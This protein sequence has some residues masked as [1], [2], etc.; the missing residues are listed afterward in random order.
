MKKKKYVIPD[1]LMRT[2]EIDT[3]KK[4]PLVD[5]LKLTGIVDFDQDKQVNIFSLVSGNVQDIKVQ[6]GRL[7]NK[8]PGAGY[9]KKQ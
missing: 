4:C 9:C 8:R 6:L 3:V 1:S 7:C 2:L 5:A